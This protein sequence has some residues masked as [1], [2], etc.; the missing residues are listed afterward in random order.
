MGHTDSE[1][2]QIWNVGPKTKV[3]V[4]NEVKMEVNLVKHD[5]TRSNMSQIK[6]TRFRLGQAGF[7]LG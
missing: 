7:R 5:Q 4:R 2:D 1:V 6:P 3:E